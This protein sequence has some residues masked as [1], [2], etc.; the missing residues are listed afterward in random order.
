[1]NLSNK[2]KKFKLI[3]N[4][5]FNYALFS[6]ILI[7]ASGINSKSNLIWASKLETEETKTLEIKND[8]KL[9]MSDTDFDF[10]KE[11][12]IDKVF[13]KQNEILEK[14][15]KWI[16][17]EENKIPEITQNNIIRI[18]TDIIY[19]GNEYEISLAKKFFD[20]MD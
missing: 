13:N 14:F 12:V 7:F 3:F 16:Q 10:F 6:V 8:K 1:M 4:H 2:K 18:V 20:F 9:E 11:Q 15:I 17:K 5:A 19:G